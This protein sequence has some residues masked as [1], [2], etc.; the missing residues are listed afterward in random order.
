MPFRRLVRCLAG[1]IL[2]FGPALATGQ[3]YPTQPIRIVV[4]YTSGGPVDTLA[5][6]LAERMAPKLG[7]PVL[8]ENKPGANT[9]IGARAVIEAAAD[10]HTL[11]LATTSVAT[12]T[13][14]VKEPGY[15]V[16]DFVPVVAGASLPIVF[17]VPPALG[18]KTV[19]DFVSRLK[20]RPGQANY[21][22]AGSFTELLSDR[23]VSL[24]GVKMTA[25]PYKG[26]AE[27]TLAVVQGNVQMFSAGV[28]AAISLIRAGKLQPLAVAADQRSV[29]LP[30]VPTFKELGYADMIGST[31]M[32]I[33]A[34]ARTPAPVIEKL[35]HILVEI[36]GTE[37]FRTRIVNVG[38][39]VW[40]TKPEDLRAFIRNDLLLW[41]KDVKRMGIKPQ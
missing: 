12:N 16:D 38:L 27:A 36:T 40:S 10:G 6:I 25:V 34:R 22:T 35:R 13:L 30:D 31:W 20:S 37:E 24:A 15:T 14:I 28:A 9:L 7:K 18:V 5:R 8:V 23:F 3:D 17:V 21:S 1:A 29:L 11:L 2:A 39:D 26:G 4:P 32:A 33:A 41:E 19:P